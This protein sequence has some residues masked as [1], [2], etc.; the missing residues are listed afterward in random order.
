[1]PIHPI[2]IVD[3][4]ADK[5]RPAFDAVEKLAKL[6]VGFD[7][8]S[9]AEVPQHADVDAG[10]GL[11]IDRLLDRHAAAQMNVVVDH[12]DIAAGEAIASDS[13]SARSPRPMPDRAAG[14]ASSGSRR[15]ATR[16][17]A[18]RLPGSW[19]CR[20]I[21]PRESTRPLARPSVRLLRLEVVD[22]G[23]S[24]HPHAIRLPITLSRT[25]NHSLFATQDL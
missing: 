2:A 12:R 3:L 21:V 9:L 15:T 17:K 25:R 4:D 19:P 1:M 7:R 24:V 13:P 8:P 23:N 14:S 18:T 11:A 5:H 6:I 20:A 16:R 10:D 22:R